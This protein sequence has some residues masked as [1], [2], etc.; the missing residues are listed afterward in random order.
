MLSNARFFAL[1]EV[2]TGLDATV[3]LQ[4]FSSLRKIAS[5]QRIG[6]VAALLQP[7][8]ELVELFDDII[9][10]R[11]GAV[12]YH[13]PRLAL[14][15]YLRELGF[16]PP[17]VWS[18]HETAGGSC[19]SQTHDLESVVELEDL[20]ANDLADWLSEWIT[21]PKRRHRKDLRLRGE[22][23]L[24]GLIPPLTTDE[25]VRSWKSHHLY[26]SLIAA[27][28][29]RSMSGVD[30]ARESIESSLTLQ[31]YS[32]RYVHHPFVHLKYVTNRQILLLLRNWNHLSEFQKYSSL[33]Y[34]CIPVWFS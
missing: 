13:G 22:T 6:I 12:V 34:E 25:L 19:T 32:R 5:S 17:A 4:I 20:S 29:S 7:T 24:T 3:A 16:F 1:D 11:D 33:L 28:P 8:P 14:P 27:A 15:D 21:H 2:S 30:I 26:L 31:Q 9:L 10:L 18:L 23:D